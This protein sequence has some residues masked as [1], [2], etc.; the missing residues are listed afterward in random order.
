MPISKEAE[1]LLLASKKYTGF[2]LQQSFEKKDT[3]RIILTDYIHAF[4]E[5]YKV[6]N[7]PIN[8]LVLLSKS[9]K[10]VQVCL[11]FMEGQS[12][13]IEFREVDKL[14]LYTSWCI[15]DNDTITIHGEYEP[16]AWFISIAALHAKLIEEAILSGEMERIVNRHYL[17]GESNLLKAFESIENSELKEKCKPLFL[18]IVKHISEI[19]FRRVEIET[20]SQNLTYKLFVDDYIEVHVIMYGNWRECEY[21]VFVK[22]TYDHDYNEIKCFYSFYK[23]T[24][25]SMEGAPTIYDFYYTDEKVFNLTSNMI[26]FYKTLNS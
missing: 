15:F 25:E 22:N 7:L 3:F 19:A 26:N 14:E 2:I 16:Q 23:C 5:L 18:R 6:Y 12:E 24:I 10:T 1:N 4:E 20:A 17:Y 11:N 9:Q 13:C 21:G 8:A